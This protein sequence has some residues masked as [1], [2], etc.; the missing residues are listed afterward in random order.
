MGH[1]FLSEALTS[2]AGDCGSHGE[3]EKGRECLP[4]SVKFYMAAFQNR[5]KFQ[6]LLIVL[7]NSGPLN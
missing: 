7:L 3:K 6:G 1:V 5:Q 2:V 4:F